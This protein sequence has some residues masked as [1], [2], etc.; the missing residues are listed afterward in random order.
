MRFGPFGPAAHGALLGGKTGGN[1]RLA[2]KYSNLQEFLH[3]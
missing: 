1:N 3:D 2:G